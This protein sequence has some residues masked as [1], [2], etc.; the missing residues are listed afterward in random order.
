MPEDEQV[1]SRSISAQ[2]TGYV[3]H[4]LFL[5]SLSSLISWL[6]A[7]LCTREGAVLCWAWFW[8]GVLLK[9]RKV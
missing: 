4:M 5:L 6:A 7:Q 2:Y 9:R 1:E 3:L 8:F